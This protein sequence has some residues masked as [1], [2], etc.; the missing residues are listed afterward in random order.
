MQRRGTKFAQSIA[1]GSLGLGFTAN[2]PS[3]GSIYKHPETS[4]IVSAD[5]R[6]DNQ[7]VLREALNL[8]PITSF[9]EL[10]AKAYF[11]WGPDCPRFLEGDFAFIIWDP[12]EQHLFCARDRLGLK[13]LLYHFTPHK[14]FGCATD[15]KT[16]FIHDAIQ[17][18][19][20]E[21]RL[22]DFF[23]G[24]EGI[25]LLYTSPSPRDQRGSRMPSSA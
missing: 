13:Q 11:K 12:R 19:P 25:C 5:A 18:R 15:A 9:A 6:L 14:V 22:L 4:I 1:S 17:Q 24:L 23:V 7:E 16:L 10:I 21:T 20:N 3:E 2:H 8:S